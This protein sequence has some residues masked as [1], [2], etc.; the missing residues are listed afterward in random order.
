MAETSKQTVASRP[1][2]TADHMISFADRAANAHL[3]LCD[4]C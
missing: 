1:V 3:R 2:V 4:T